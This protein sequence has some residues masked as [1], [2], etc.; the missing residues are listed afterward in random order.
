MSKGG[1]GDGQLMRTRSVKGEGCLPPPWH[2]APRGLLRSFESGRG[3]AKAAS[4][5]SPTAACTPEEAP[6]AARALTSDD[7]GDL[8][9]AKVLVAAQAVVALAARVAQPAVADAVADLR[10]TWG[11]SVGREPA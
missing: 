6:H 9:K 7:G 10:V 3:S 11:A 5:T 8:L 2:A 1:Q 4:S